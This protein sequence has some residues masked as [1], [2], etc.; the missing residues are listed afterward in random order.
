MPSG[1]SEH[2]TQGM[3]WSCERVHIQHVGAHQKTPMVTRRRRDRR[4]LPQNVSSCD[5]PR[6]Y[7]GT[8]SA[9]LILH[10]RA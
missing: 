9:R 3:M 5:T 2:A 4:S 10:Q 7:T 8:R 6:W 1:R